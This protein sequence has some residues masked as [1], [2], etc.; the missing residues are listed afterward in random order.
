MGAVLVTAALMLGVYTIVEAADHGWGSSHTLGFGAFV[1]AAARGVRRAPGDAAN[2]LLPLRIFRSRNVSGA[3]I[4]QVLMV[5]GHVRDVLPRRAADLQRVLGY[6]ALET[7]LAFLPVALGIGLLSLGFSA[8]L[9]PRFGER[10]VPLR[11]AR[12]A[13]RR[14]RLAHPRAR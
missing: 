10:A 7:G 14:A 8:R 9:N 6:D 1:G 4:I 3:N 12:P 2:P 11:R 5:G 13:R